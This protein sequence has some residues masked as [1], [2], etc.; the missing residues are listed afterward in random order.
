MMRSCRWS[1]GAHRVI[2]QSHQ[3]PRLFL[4][5]CP[6][7][8]R[9]RCPS[10]HCMFSPSMKEE[11]VEKGRVGKALEESHENAIGPV[12]LSGVQAEALAS[13]HAELKDRLR[14]IGQGFDRLRAQGQPP[15]LRRRDWVHGAPGAGPLGHG[16]VSQLHREG[17]GVLPGG[18]QVKV[19]IE[20]HNHYQKQ[21]EI[22]HQKLKHVESFGDQEHITR[23]KERYA[24]LEEKTKE[25]GY[26]VKKHVQDLSSCISRAR[27]N[28]LWGHS[29]LRGPAAQP[30]ARRRR[31]QPGVPEEGPRPSGL[32]C[33]PAEPQG[34]RGGDR[35]GGAVA[36]RADRL[37]RVPRGRE[38]ELHEPA[39]PAW[40]PAAAMSAAHGVL[41]AMLQ[42]H[43]LRWNPM[44]ATG[45]AMYRSPYT[46]V[47]VFN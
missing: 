11:R 25:L 26:K 22:S 27:H 32:T 21:L 28:E 43:G 3:G 1:A 37:P 9:L 23:N 29:E 16:Q 18:A 41:A 39:P 30:A 42:G 24:M 13:R 19:K 38:E 44:T 8:L 20:K 17:A 47:T 10:S 31:R 5:L 34:R 6:F 40:Q 36:G 46:Y 4:A 15:G 2:S 12:D 14:S 45:N 33:L 7:I 35:P